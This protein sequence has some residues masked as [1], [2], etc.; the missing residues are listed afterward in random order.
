MWIY[1]HKFSSVSLFLLESD[2]DWLNKIN[3]EE[4]FHVKEWSPEHTFL[5]LFGP[6]VILRCLSARANFSKEFALASRF[7]HL[8]LITDKICFGIISFE[9]MLHQFVLRFRLKYCC[10]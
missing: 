1:M 3:K 2:L 7:K 4:D 8:K 9:I 10:L 5:L 6:M